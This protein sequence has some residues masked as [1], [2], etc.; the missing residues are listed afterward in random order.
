MARGKLY[1]VCSKLPPIVSR[2][3]FAC[4]IAFDDQVIVHI[5]QILRF[6]SKFIFSTI[7][8]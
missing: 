8:N 6:E 4:L 5:L 3:G 1:S 7:E 2:I